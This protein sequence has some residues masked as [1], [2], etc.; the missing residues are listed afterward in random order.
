MKAVLA[1]GKPMHSWQVLRPDLEIDF[2]LAT[3]ALVRAETL[4]E[5][6]GSQKAALESYEEGVKTLG[7]YVLDLETLH[8]WA[9]EVRCALNPARPLDRLPLSRKIDRIVQKLVR[10]VETKRD[11]LVMPNLRLVLKEVFRFRPLGMHRSDLFQ[12]GSIGLHKAAFRFDARRG[13]RFSTYATFWIRQA[14]RKSLIDKGR[15]I[16]IPQAIQEELRRGHETLE[17]AEVDRLRR[18]MRETIL[19][20]C[21]ESPDSTDRG[22]FEIR[23]RS[24]PEIGELLKMRR[25][26]QAVHEALGILTNRQRDVLQRRF[27]LAGERPQTLEEIGGDLKLSR[28]RIR[29]IEQEALANMRKRGGLGEVY[30]ELTDVDVVAAGMRG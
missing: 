30:E 29:Q 24:V 8:Q 11:Q 15:M 5:A 9:R 3:R 21:K 23:D 25:M 4:L 17:A 6:D 1:G 28:E 16:R 20:S 12:E 22:C 27:G 19:F 10:I 2:A 26:P 13:I 14:I 18:I 7:R